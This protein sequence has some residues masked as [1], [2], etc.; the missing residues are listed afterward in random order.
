MQA[1]FG[2]PMSPKQAA[3]Q[4]GLQP[5]KLYYHFDELAAAG[6]IRVAST[7]EHGNITER[8]WEPVAT[9]MRVSP[10][11]FTQGGEGAQAFIEAIESAFAASSS[12]VRRAVQRAT[13][14]ELSQTIERI[15]FMH[16]MWALSDDDHAEFNRRMRALIEEYEAISAGSDAPANRRITLLYHAIPTE[17]SDDQ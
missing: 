17:V 12:D 11:L 8:F 16:R 6:L 7:E 1:L 9:S 14:C 5:T 3:K 4:L 15:T 13:S 10:D 2:G